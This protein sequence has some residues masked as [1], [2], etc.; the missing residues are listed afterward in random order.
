MNHL[1]RNYKK[2][3][4]KKLKALQ[5]QTKFIVL[6]DNYFPKRK[7]KLKEKDLKSPWIT[8]CIK[9]SS[10]R[11]QRLYEKLFKKRTEKNELEYKNYKKLLESVKKRSK[12]AT[13]FQ[14]NS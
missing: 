11:K 8:S 10:K 13:L 4:G 5:T 1:R 7:I 14:P 3:I 6:Y 9:K 12:K 2:L